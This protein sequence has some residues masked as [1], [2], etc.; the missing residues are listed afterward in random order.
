MQRHRVIFG[1]GA[2][3]PVGGW[4]GGAVR[5]ASGGHALADARVH[6]GPRHFQPSQL[7]QWEGRHV[8]QAA[9]GAAQLLKQHLHRETHTVGRSADNRVKHGLMGEFSLPESGACPG[10]APCH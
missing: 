9:V 5:Q 7:T 10:K 4:S 8:E 2:L 1:S 3:R 6:P